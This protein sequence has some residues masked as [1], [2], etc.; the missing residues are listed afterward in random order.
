MA[1]KVI[2]PIVENGMSVDT[3]KDHMQG[4][5]TD[6]SRVSTSMNQIQTQGGWEAYWNKSDNIRKIAHHVDLI[7]SVLQKN[8]ELSILIMNGAVN[9]KRD[10]SVIMAILEESND[11]YSDQVE[12]VEALGRFRKMVDDLKSRDD[13]LD[14]LVDATNNHGE[15]IDE[16]ISHNTKIETSIEYLDNMLTKVQMEWNDKY[17]IINND[18]ASVR[19]TIESLSQI[20]KTYQNEWEEKHK[21]I[22]LD[23]AKLIQ[24]TNSSLLQNKQDLDDKISSLTSKIQ[25]DSSSFQNKIASDLGSFSHG[26]NAKFSDF[27]SKYDKSLL[28]HKIA[29]IFLSLISV[30]SVVLSFIR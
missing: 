11:Q 24:D 21:G 9:I 15:N 7:G 27:Q 4:C 22:Y 10:Y 2:M 5:L 3:F 12:V 25:V 8:L 16:I 19:N 18:F 26:Q 17:A 6:I 29:I 20:F 28:Y 1:D 13:L 14:N 30:G 23:Y